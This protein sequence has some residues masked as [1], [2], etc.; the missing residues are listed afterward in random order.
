MSIYCERFMYLGYFES[1][2]SL[3]SA[4]G[5]REQAQSSDGHTVKEG[6]A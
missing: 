2:R 5:R 1:A 3:L 6:T 4:V